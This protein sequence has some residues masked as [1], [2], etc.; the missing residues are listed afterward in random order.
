MILSSYE[1]LSLMNAKGYKVARYRYAGGLALNIIGVRNKDAR[2]NYFD[3]VISIFY[4]T[5][6]NCWQE[7]H[8]IATTLPGIPMLL[9]PM[10]SDG[11]AILVPGQ[12]I[13]SYAIGEHCGKYE[14]LIQVRPVKVYRDYDLDELY[15]ENE[16]SIEE[17]MFGINIHRASL[18][19]KVVGVD[20]AGCQVIRDRSDYERFMA[21]CRTVS[22][23]GNKLYTYTLV[24]L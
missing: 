15:D 14:A 12:Y 16:K 13:D 18:G 11:C 8:C 17:G 9:K 23:R 21:L 24:E 22:F 20:S 4:E 6:E 10:N 19:A 3:D 5:A 2:P 7:L 1:F